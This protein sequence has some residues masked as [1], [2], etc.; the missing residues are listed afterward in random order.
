MIFVTKSHTSSKSFIFKL[1][2]S[3]SLITSR[4]SPTKWIK[5]IASKTCC[6]IGEPCF[7]DCES[8]AMGS[9]FRCGMELWVK[10]N[11][12]TTQIKSQRHC[13]IRFSFCSDSSGCGFL[14]NLTQAPSLV[15]HYYWPSP[16]NRNSKVF[17][18]L[19]PKLITYQFIICL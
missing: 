3:Q 16:P 7:I 8:C 13:C 11:S 18:L 14:R 19:I 4:Q 12:L 2:R 6:L 10:I 5:T 17:S 15:G 9:D 1:S